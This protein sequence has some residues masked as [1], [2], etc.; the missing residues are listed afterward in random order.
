MGE[1]NAM[2]DNEAAAA[3]QG[4]QA[5]RYREIGLKAVAAAILYQGGT[6]PADFPELSDSGPPV[7]ASSDHDR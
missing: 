7:N 1:E 5:G 4:L 3:Q 2:D 6:E